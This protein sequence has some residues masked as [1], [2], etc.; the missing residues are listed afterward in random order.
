MICSYIPIYIVGYIVSLLQICMLYSLYAF[1]YKWF[2]MGWELHKRLAYIETNWPYFI[3]FG[4]PLAVFTQVS[5]SWII[6]YSFHVSLEVLLSF[7]VFLVG[8]YSLYCF[9]FSL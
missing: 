2:N 5:E 6:R 4:L 7:Y 8:V 1:E 3:G 9:H